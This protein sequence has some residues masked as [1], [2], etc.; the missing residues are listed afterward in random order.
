MTKQEATD[1][2]VQL[3]NT[4]E[5]RGFEIS[6]PDQDSYDLMRETLAGLGR[7]SGPDGEFFVI[8]VPATSA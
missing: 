8:K 4:Y 7:Q 5:G 6:M 1:M 3:L 2:A